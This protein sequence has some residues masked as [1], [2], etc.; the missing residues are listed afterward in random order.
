[1]KP[2]VHGQL[3]MEGYPQTTPVENAD[4][5]VAKPGNRLAAYSVL[6]ESWCTNEDAGK[7]ILHRRGS[8]R[9]HFERLMSEPVSRGGGGFSE[10]CGRYG[11]F[12]LNNRFKRISLAT[13][14]VS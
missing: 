14:G 7:T 5:F 11:K 6:F 4:D 13:P 8:L 3:R 10:F 1:M 9:G 12:N 2:S